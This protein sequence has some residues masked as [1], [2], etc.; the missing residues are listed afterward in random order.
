MRPI[1]VQPLIKMISLHLNVCMHCLC[2][3]VCFAEGAFC[4]RVTTCLYRNFVREFH[5]KTKS[6]SVITMFVMYNDIPY[7]WGPIRIFT[8]AA[9]VCAHI[10]VDSCV[11]GG[12]IKC[13]QAYV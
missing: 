11:G 7:S 6:Y 12:H 1:D 5:C 2:S 13:V 10:C 4:V 3:V 8:C 9:C